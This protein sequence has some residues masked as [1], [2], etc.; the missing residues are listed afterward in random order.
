MDGL[1]YENIRG[2]LGIDKE[3]H[4]EE[5]MARRPVGRLGHSGRGH[6][7]EH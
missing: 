3:R 4:V 1:G 7:R 6:D 2:E 5:D